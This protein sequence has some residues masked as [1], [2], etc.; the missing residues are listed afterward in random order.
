MDV[1]I[2]DFFEGGRTDRTR[3]QGVTADV[4]P[5][6]GVRTDLA[7]FHWPGT[8]TDLHRS[9]SRR[10]DGEEVGMGRGKMKGIITNDPPFAASRFS[11]QSIAN[12]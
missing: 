9:P 5:R 7:P 10:F 1:L 4:A 11:N 3:R 12:W 2:R 8:N 6:Q